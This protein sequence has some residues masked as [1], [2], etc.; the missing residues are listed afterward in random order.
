MNKTMKVADKLEK[1]L[2]D[3]RMDLNKHL[4]QNIALNEQLKKAMTKF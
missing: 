1:E 3:I 4:G 2:S